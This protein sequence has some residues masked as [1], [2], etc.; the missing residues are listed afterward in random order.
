MR[1]RR[2]TRRG[3][4]SHPTCRRRSLSR[5]EGAH[6]RGVC[7][8]HHHP[9]NPRCAI[10]A[11]SFRNGRAG[12]V[13]PKKSFKKLGKVSTP[14]REGGAQEIIPWYMVRVKKRDLDQSY[15][16][17]VLL[18]PVRAERKVA[19]VL[20]FFGLRRAKDLGRVEVAFAD[21]FLR[22]GLECLVTHRF[23]PFSP[24]R[25]RVEIGT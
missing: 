8:C 5:V 12:K 19:L 25:V 13:G 17:R 7:V 23:A 15:Q 3:F 16:Q 14:H 21:F 22:A 4:P 18:G 9:N 10:I 2:R 11:L 6:A 1:T 20:S 24:A